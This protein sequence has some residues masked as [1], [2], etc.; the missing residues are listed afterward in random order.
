MPG[1]GKHFPGHGYTE[2]DSHTELP[3]DERSLEDLVVDDLVP[4]GVLFASVLVF[5]VI[6]LAA[7]V[8]TRT[9]LIR[10]KGPAW[11][12]SRFLP[13]LHPVAVAT[14]LA[15]QWTALARKVLGVQTSWRGRRLAPQ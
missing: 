11:F 2:A 15:I 10:A 5:I 12:S 3:V 6:P 1:V 8:A 7:G 14:F 13:A 9:A 4:F